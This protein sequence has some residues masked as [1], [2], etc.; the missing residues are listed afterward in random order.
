LEVCKKYNLKYNLLPGFKE[1]LNGHL[2]HLRDM[3]EKK[4]F[5]GFAKME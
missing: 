3:G 5:V 2:N 1:A 4:K